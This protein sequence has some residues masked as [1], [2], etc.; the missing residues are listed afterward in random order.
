MYLVLY[1]GEGSIAETSV[2]TL[3][4]SADFTIFITFITILTTVLLES[5]QS[6]YLNLEKIN[7]FLDTRMYCKLRKLVFS[8]PSAK[9]MGHKS[10]R[11]KIGPSLTDG[12]RTRLVL[13][14]YIYSWC[15]LYMDQNRYNTHL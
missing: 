14:T 9:C 2:K 8:G 3:W 4:N 13:K 11:K 10:K 5:R 6:L 1:P 7:N 15:F 12:P